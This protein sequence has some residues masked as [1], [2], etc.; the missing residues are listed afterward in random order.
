[1]LAMPSLR[2]LQQ[3]FVAAVLDGAETALAI[4]P[5]GDAAERVAIYRRAVFANYR[6]AL[7]AT[8]PVVARLTG[9]PFFNAAVD[10]FVHT[11][12]STSGDLNVYGDGFATFLAD[13]A[14]A[15]ELPYLPDVAR[16]EWAI[17]ES[18]RAPD[19]PRAPE[20][21]LAAL[22]AVVPNRL[23]ALRVTLEPSCRLV[24][25]RYPILRLW[26]VNQPHFDGDDQVMLDEG[27]NALLIRRDEHG[28]ALESL[29]RGEFAWLSAL[30]AGAALGTAIDAALEA[31]AAFD[32]GTALS[33]HIAAAT[34][35]SILA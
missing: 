2:E 28:I 11:H 27:A 29:D 18:G 22:G 7:G 15:A 4:T 19:A 13:Y 1:M 9:T 30:A 20:S 10:A 35:A 16:L 12:P 25:S 17:D 5:A 23:P 6:N 34:I 3:G 33:K 14:P 31:D 32:L 24:A 8:F 26:Q 21:V